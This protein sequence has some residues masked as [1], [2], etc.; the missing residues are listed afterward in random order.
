MGLKVTLAIMVPCSAHA[1]EEMRRAATQCGL[2]A[3]ADVVITGWIS[4]AA[5]NTRYC[6]ASGL[7]L[8]LWDD[9]RSRTRMPTKLGGKFASGVPVITCPVGDLGRL[10]TD[11]ETAFLCRPGDVE[12]FASRMVCAVT[13]PELAKRI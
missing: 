12:A 10:L 4:E 6:Q 13:D 11:G 2:R 1:A 5:R 7:L 8:P 9:D 3:D